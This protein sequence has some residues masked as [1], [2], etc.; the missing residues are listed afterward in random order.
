MRFVVAGAVVD[1]GR[2]LLAQRSYPPEVA[3]RWELPGGKAED[4][5]TLHDAL[6]REL[7][8]E[9][10]VTVDVGERLTEQVRLGP[11]LTMIALRAHIVDGSP[12]ATEHSGLCWVGA[13]GLAAMRDRGELVPADEAWV[14]ELIAVL[15]D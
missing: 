14:P 3:G 8:E 6:I 15:N 4:G 13:D 12:R 11:D 9:L 2:L 7:S 1:D 5:E 10:G